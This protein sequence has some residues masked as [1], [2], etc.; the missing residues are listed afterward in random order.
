MPP[1]RENMRGDIERL[2]TYGTECSCS[3]RLALAHD[4]LDQADK[5]F[6]LLVDLI[7]GR[8]DV[9]AKISSQARIDYA[10]TQVNAALQDMVSFRQHVL[11]IRLLA[12]GVLVIEQLLHI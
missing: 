12:T 4:R 1:L 8:K 10:N 7:V 3:P 6:R 5:C 9:D 2:P 11:P